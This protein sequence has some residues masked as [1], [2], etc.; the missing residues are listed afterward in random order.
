MHYAAAA[1][2]ALGTTNT[3]TRI[4]HTVEATRLIVRAAR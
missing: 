4:G 1:D 3:D 2:G